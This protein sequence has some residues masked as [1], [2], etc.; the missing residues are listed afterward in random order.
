MKNR[1]FRLCSTILVLALLVNMLPTSIFAEAF[2]EQ[3]T[4]Q[5]SVSLEP[6]AS[7]KAY[8]VEELTNKR[9]EYTKEFLLSNGLHIATVYAEP[10]HYQKDGKWAEIDNT[11]I[12]KS[13]GTYRNTAGVWNVALP[14]N[15]STGAVSIAKDGYT[16]SF[17]MAG[18]LLQPG[19][20][21][22]MSE[23]SVAPQQIATEETVTVSVSGAEHSFGVQQAQATSAAMQSPDIAAAK[24]AAAYPE[25]V[26]EKNTSGLLYANVYTGTDIRY[27]LQSNQVKES[28]I[29]SAYNARLRGYSYILNTGNMIPRLQRDNSILFYD[30]KEENIIM[31]MPA[32]FLLD[33]NYAF[34]DE[35]QVSLSGKNGVY[36]LV[37]LL[38]QQ[39]LADEDR[40][41]PVILD[42]VVQ[43]EI[44]RSNIQDHT[45][46]SV[47]TFSPTK[48]TLN[49]GVSSQNGV[50]RIFLKYNSLPQISS[51]DVIVEAYVTL[52][53]LTDGSGSSAMEVHKVNQAWEIADLNWAEWSAA[54]KYNA[55]VEDVNMVSDAGVYTWGITDIVRGWYSGENTGMM[56]KLQDSEEASSKV[57]YRQFASAEY[58]K[59]DTYQPNLIIKFL[60]GTGLESYWNYSSASAGRAGT[61]YVNTYT[62]GLTWVRSDM[63]FGGSR[64]PVSINHIYNLSDAQ[65]NSYGLGYGWRT[66]FN[67]KV[68]PYT[69]NEDYYVWEDGD[70]TRHYFKKS[71][72]TTYKDEDGLEL[73]L[74][75]NGSGT[76]TFS[77]TDKKDNVSYFDAN[78][79]LTK[80]ANNQETKSSIE[81][82][83]TTTDGYRISSVSQVLPVVQKNTTT[84]THTVTRLYQFSYNDAGLLSRICY[85]GS[86]NT[87]IT[88]ITFGYS[89]EQD[90]T[91][92]TYPDEAAVSYEYTAHIL[93][94]AADIDGY[95]LCYSYQALGT[96]ARRVTQVSAENPNAPQDE[97]GAGNLTLS[98]AHNQTTLTDHNG[99]TE[100]LHF[101]HRGN[102]IS[103]QDDEGRAQ[104]AAYTANTTTDTGKANQ[105]T[106]S[107]KLQNTVVNL[108]SDSSFENG[109]PWTATTNSTGIVTTDEQHHGTKSLWVKNTV[110]GPVFTIANDETYT[111]SAYVQA[112]SAAQIG[113]KVGS[114]T[115]SLTP[116]PIGTGFV[117]YEVSY[118]N[119]TGNAVQATPFL[120]AGE[121]IGA[122]FDDVQLEKMPT[123]SRYNLVYNSDFT[124]GLS[125]WTSDQNNSV[126]MFVPSQVQN[127]AAPQLDGNVLTITGVPN[128]KGRL[129][130]T[131]PVSGEAGDSF[132]F[133]GWASADSAPLFPGAGSGSATRYFCLALTFNYTDDTTKQVVVP[134]NPGS[135]NLWQYASQAAVAEKDYD[136]IVIQA[137]Y[138]YNANSAK[139]D[140]IQ[141][142]K[143]E[144]GTSYTYDEDGNIIRVVD[145]QKKNTTYEYDDDTG[146]LLQ[147]LEDN[148]A[149]VTYTY[150][151]WHNVKTSV[152][153]E[154]LRYEFDYDTYGNNTAVSIGS[155]TTKISSS[156]L[157]SSTGCYPI[158]A[159][160]ALD[161]VTTYSYNE[162][163]G[164]LNWV[165]YPNGE[166]TKTTYDYD[167]MYRTAMAECTTDTGA[168]MQV[169]YTYEGDY[170]T[171]V[172]TPSTTYRFNYGNFGL[173]S[174]IM[175][176]N[177]VL[178]G[179]TYNN[180]L[181][182]QTLTYGNGDRVDYAYDTKGRSTTDTYEDGDTV[183]YKYDNNGNLA[184]KID[185]ATGRT[186]T[187][188]YDLTERLV[189][190][191][192]KGTNYSHRV[193]Y[194]YDAKN[195]LTQLAETTNGVTVTT[196][197][198]YD[199]DNRVKTVT[200]GNT[201]VEYTYDTYGRLNQKVTKNGSVT[202]K[203][204]SYTYTTTDSG[205]SSQIATYTTAVGSNSTTYSYT[206]DN[207]GNITAVSDGTNTTSY[208]YDS[209][210]QLVRENNQEKNFT[211]TWEYDNAGNILNRKEYPYTTGT[212]TSTPDT[213]TVS[214]GY[215]TVPIVEEG[216]HNPVWGDRLSSVNG[217][218]VSYD[219]V[220]NPTSGYG[221]MYE[222]EHGRQLK[223]LYSDVSEMTYEYNADGMRTKRTDGTTTYEYV[224][225]GSQLTQMSVGED[226]FNFTYDA[227]GTPLTISYGNSVYYYVTNLQGDVI[228]IL[229]SS[230]NTVGAYT[231]DAWGVCEAQ[232]F[233][234]V[235]FYNPLRY[236]GY[237][238]DEE[239]G[240]YYLQSRY[241]NPELGRFL[242]ADVFYSTGQGL[243][244]NNMF[245][246]CGNNPINM[247][248]QSGNMPDWIQ[249][250]VQFMKKAVDITAKSVCISANPIGRTV[251]VVA[252]YNRNRLNKDDYSE[253]ELQ[254]NSY[255]PEKPSSDKFH[256]NN[257]IDGMRNRKYVIGTWGSSEIVYYG[258]GTVNNT[259]EDR[260]TFNVY[261][262]DNGFL[263]VTVHGTF[264]VVP[265]I[266]WGNSLEDSTTIVDRVLLIF[267]G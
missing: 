219:G 92:V 174:S 242:N 165:Q 142:F 145:L 158:S 234:T 194:E 59:Y 25:L 187:Y 65:D 139:F 32:P 231:Y 154:E 4:M 114:E 190:Y 169:N 88:D 93:T 31:V 12:A 249:Q 73:T 212:L 185:S 238:Y 131:V 111:L 246:Y 232:I 82:A 257:Q 57:S 118:T 5:D 205:I 134:F 112:E 19:G 247:S 226:T 102:L 245:A 202:F 8:V 44:D 90:L 72:S 148:K 11:L 2:E 261:S 36:T 193:S 24:A 176:G 188:Y 33:A 60:S 144:F 110:H 80:Q 67:Q 260:G 96:S 21:E 56:F 186:T 78:G 197:Y 181:Y 115:V 191:E 117:R 35:L 58:T 235:E 156:A 86:N 99:N 162:D 183:A 41:W 127:S 150:D 217:A 106:L 95:R 164:E 133:S 189:G 79:R 34:S 26:A 236:R 124:Q 209:A 135:E 211:H 256:Q 159:T 255:A 216:E 253:Q 87:E 153:D 244:G 23:S 108:L 141:L 201:T 198:T 45:I 161:K 143:E 54:A 46:S 76:E 132:V 120:L 170:L 9:T 97:S 64:M 206:Y 6:I 207:N 223:K 107:S 163:T 89:T 204:E 122:Y 70:G 91:T 129:K 28:V 227:N 251:A 98:Y 83:Y 208:T 180:D 266:F 160:N 137:S 233:D 10:V 48:A 75:T 252:H 228:E 167:S 3:L 103:I 152:T 18:Q 121:S 222:W 195:N 55:S 259:P 37:Y 16:L 184:K 81:I 113:F 182:L 199:D 168:H 220:G 172:A 151:D 101:N 200:T 128:K 221:W 68:Y 155:G 43:P 116:I 85:K 42:P 203:T 146:D 71:N 215:P 263:N 125:G 39:W 63:S 126:N 147:I 29:L 50:Q 53:K 119:S 17:Q 105:L 240:L 192:E 136:S 177:N 100:I 77:I 214:Y 229:D 166:S 196:A 178:A 149:K 258:D 171:A 224:Y 1:F 123:A 210:N 15:L 13:D 104:Y 40:A 94:K 51:A 69:E 225:N 262:G 130:Q 66:N 243:L 74:K 14:D 27:D 22:L 218:T 157:Y 230:G 254:N 62:G 49:C 7:E 47:T 248:D 38:P 179:Y 173:R 237:V 250:T 30:E 241:Y 61:G 20:L 264:D 175:V 109:N 52:C 84:V 213:P 239:T 140:G 267:G 138:S 265:Y